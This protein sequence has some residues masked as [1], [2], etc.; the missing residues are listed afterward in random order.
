METTNYY[1]ECLV[2]NVGDENMHVCLS[3]EC[4][5]TSRRRK[6]FESKSPI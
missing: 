5:K 2:Y 4:R 3:L 6:M 1:D